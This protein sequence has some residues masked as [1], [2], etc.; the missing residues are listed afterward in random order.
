[1]DLCQ[2]TG[3]ATGKASQRTKVYQFMQGTENKNS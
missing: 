3:P 1:M 2:I